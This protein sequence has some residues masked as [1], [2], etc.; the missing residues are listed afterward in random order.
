MIKDATKSVAASS[1]LAMTR[2]LSNAGVKLVASQELLREDSQIK[3][4]SITL[5]RQHQEEPDE[6]ERCLF[7][8]EGA[9]GMDNDPYD[10][11][12]VSHSIDAENCHPCNW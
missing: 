9:P 10:S 4:M 2:S 7:A 12:R 5:T 8:G 1:E 11:I 3:W 6:D